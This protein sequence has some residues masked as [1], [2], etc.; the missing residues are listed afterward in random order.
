MITTLLKH[1]DLLNALSGFTFH[2]DQGWEGYPPTG[3][4]IL[5]S[6]LLGYTPQGDLERKAVKLAQL[7][8]D[9]PT[10]F[11]ADPLLHRQLREVMRDMYLDA[12][13][14]DQDLRDYFCELYSK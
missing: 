6:F 5:R 11:R 4:R 12:G 3:P 2:Q 1:E 7:Y 9:D 14:K 13:F 10:A 8:V